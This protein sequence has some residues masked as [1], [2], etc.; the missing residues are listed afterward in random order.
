MALHP[1]IS[2]VVPMYDVEPYAAD[3]LASLASQQLCAAC[4]REGV[5]Y[6]IIIVD[7][8]SHDGTGAVIDAFARSRASDDAETATSVQTPDTALAPVTVLRTSNR[9]LSA[10][11]NLG[12]QRAR[13]RFITFVDGD[14]IV[15]PH[16]ICTLADGLR[17]LHGNEPALVAGPRA[18]FAERRQL[19]D[20]RREWERSSAASNGPVMPAMLSREDA[21]RLMLRG[22]LEVSATAKLLPRS[23]YLAHPFPEGHTFED[24]SSIIPLL[25]SSS[26]V[27]LLQRPEYWYR[28]RRN[29]LSHPLTPSMAQIMDLHRATA[30]LDEHARQFFAEQSDA[31]H[32]EAA[33]NDA[34]R[35][36]LAFQLAVQ[37][38]R[39]HRMIRAVLR[40]GRL[41][42]QHAH[43]GRMD[44]TLVQQVR[45]AR[46]QS[47]AVPGIGFASR[48]RIRLFCWNRLVYDVLFDLYDAMRR[49]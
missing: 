27:A 40:S 30:A 9:G 42:D 49:R 19:T 31:A 5:S 46:A 1:A 14:D 20:L 45:D 43:L 37:R 6:D 15:S 7:D 38:M 34:A 47:L 13:G 8:G 12:V 26:R 16:Y 32:T 4:Q 22:E 17:A 21:V 39:L 10:A 18:P 48:M 36:E 24:L 3:C 23:Y 2:V 44:A 41:L 28:Q 25:A 11:R 29:S 33:Q 35:D